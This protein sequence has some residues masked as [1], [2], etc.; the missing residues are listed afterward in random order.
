MLQTSFRRASSHRRGTVGMA[1]MYTGP[2][3][4]CR[5][6]SLR[7]RPKQPGPRRDVHFAESPD[8]L[9]MIVAP[10]VA[11]ELILVTYRRTP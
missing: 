6:P 8:G 2:S 5:R 10:R 11:V 9:V 4:L 1:S 3:A 7:E